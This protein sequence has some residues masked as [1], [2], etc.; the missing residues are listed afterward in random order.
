M[1]QITILYTGDIHAHVDHLLRAAY[2]A[3]VQR[4]ELSAVGRH[5]IL[6][7]AGD[8]EDRAL[9]ESDLSKGAAMF[10]LLRAAGYDA[11][12]IGNGA[13]LSY[14]P[15]V[16]ERIARES[17][18][19]LV[20]ANMQSRGSQPRPLPGLTPTLVLACGP[21]RVGLIGLTSEM[22]GVYSQFYP[23]TMPDARTITRQRL[24]TLRQGGCQVVG[25]LSHLG[26]EHDI[27]LARHIPGLDFIIGGHSHTMLKNPTDVDGVP[28]CHTGDYGQHLGR[29]DLSLDEQG[30]ITRWH[31]QVFRVPPEMPK[32][33]TA[34]NEWQAIQDEIQHMLR[35]PVGHISDPLDIASDRACGIGQLLAD[36]LR[37]RLRANAA[38]C[39]TG[40]IQTGLSAG[41]VTLGD[42]VRA[43]RSPANAGL[44]QVTGAQIVEALEHG[45]DP[46]VWQQ[47]PHMTRGTMIGILQVS[48]LRYRLTPT[49]P[50]GERVSDVHIIGKPIDPDATYR[51]AAT[52]YE[53]IPQRGY[54]PNLAPEQITFDMPWVVREVLQQ[55]L[56][57]FTPLTPG[58]RPRIET[59]GIGSSVYIG[60]AAKIPADRLPGTR[61]LEEDQVYIGPAARGSLP[62][63]APDADHDTA[64]YIGPV[65]R[66]SIRPEEHA[67]DAASPDES[68]E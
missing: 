5:S 57:R 48:G 65:V 39:M 44:A 47:K 13:A 9:I 29:L 26:Y 54:F 58:T 46:T 45:A 20:C 25:V 55:H 68:P 41:T 24:H 56:E 28:V 37:A 36:A 31:G 63:T 43:C 1:T 52:D 17:Q 32:H 53:L 34:A 2:L 8:I 51:I 23:V 50:P 66:P 30:H 27:E 10:R 59:P 21:V 7:D 42:L 33:T 11:S 4:Y 15:Q 19:P 22:D 12:A 60:P 61:P 67:N 62:A 18:L 49:A 35:E 6:L 64:N 40:H 3:E 14:G 38:L 16:L